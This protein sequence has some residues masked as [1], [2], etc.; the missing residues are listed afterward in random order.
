MRYV[1][2]ELVRA[3]ENHDPIDRFEAFLVKGGHAS[4][5]DLQ[6]VRTAIEPQLEEAERQA[7]D[8]PYPPPEEAL[9]DVYFEAE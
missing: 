8:S 9:R 2:K 6:A 7:L 5:R 3:W 1:P 4:R